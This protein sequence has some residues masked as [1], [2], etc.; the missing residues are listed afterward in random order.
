MGRKNKVLQGSEVITGSS[1]GPAA[2][3]TVSVI[4]P[5]YNAGDYLHGAIDSVLAQTFRDFE[6]I[7]VDDGATDGSGRVCDEYAAKDPRIKV[8][9]GRNGGICASRNVG[10]ELARG[11]WLAFCDHDDYMEPAF[12]AKLFACVEG[13]DYAIVK[14][15]RR[16]K[17]RYMDSRSFSTYEGFDHPAG[18]WVVDDLFRSVAG[19]KFY[20]TAIN[21]GIWD[22]L[23][24]RSLVV[25]NG[26]RFN[27]RFACG[28]E[29]FDF[30]ISVLKVARRGYWL[31]DI[32]YC[33]YLNI[34]VST[35]MKCHL[36][37][38]DD[39]LVT[40][41]RERETFQECNA[42]VRYAAFAQWV[43]LA[44]RYV[45]ILPR[46][47]LPMHERAAWV[48]RYYRTL[49]PDGVTLSQAA[50]F[51]WKKA[52]LL[53]CIK[54]RTVRTYLFAKMGVVRFRRMLKGD[55]R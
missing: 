51:G 41:V 23:F 36:R 4:M 49:V 24:R 13:T 9:H 45:L 42:A 37:L 26:L 55:F 38:L 6:L 2:T 5:V 10:M 19:Y 25:E 30:M 43:Y 16:T 32:V 52:V 27:E 33:H 47:P 44:I 48:L 12:L 46:C 3:P 20:C 18:E 40:A 39:F 1:G 8:K 54:L 7:L 34:D 17:R 53:V 28:C 14:A 22:C 31:P 11:K 21:A 29:D 15:N 50:E 35:L